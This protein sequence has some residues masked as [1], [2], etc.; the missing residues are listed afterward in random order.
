MSQATCIIYVRL[1]RDNESSTSV[2]SQTAACRALAESRGWDVLLVAEDVDVSGASKLESRPGMARVLDMMGSAD[3]VIAAKL[4]RFARSVLEFALLSE[5]ATNAGTILITTD[6]TL[7][8]ESSK[9]MTDILS[10]FAAHERRVIQERIA[11]SKAHLR[12]VGRWLGGAAPYGF[13]TVRRDGGTYLDVDP[14]SAA[15]VRSVA[16]R[17]LRKGE[18]LTGCMHWLN[19]NSVPSPAD[20]TRKRNGKEIKG[21]RWSTTTLRDVLINPALRGW[22]CYTPPSAPRYEIKYLVPVLNAAGEPHKVGPEIL[23]G[24][25][26]DALKDLLTARSVSPD[27]VGRSLLLHVAHCA[28][29]AG[30]LYHQRRV[31]RGQRYDSYLC[32]AAVGKHV[33]NTV[34]AAGLNAQVE[35]AFLAQFGFYGM[36]VKV[37]SRG[38]DVARELRETDEALDNLAALGARLTDGG[39]GMLAVVNQINALDAKRATLAAEAATPVREEWRDVGRTV[40]EEWA[41]RTPEGRNSLLREFGTH[42]AVTPLEK[43]AE[44]R[45]TTERT[46]VTFAG[47]EWV[48]DSNPYE[49]R[50]A[51]I[52]MEDQLSQ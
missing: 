30:P 40:A 41:S 45:F 13:R 6:G 46:A 5:F 43:T 23:A 22:L 10:A 32:T 17:I 39:R 35:A 52:E 16:E 28:V 25:T 37:T 24:E 12:R 27:R 4:D 34:N 1:S 3:Y 50:M 8:P 31:V 9:L 20:H 51:E 48:R 33:P 15:V 2:A 26:Y 7:G 21:T 38:R 18:S 36:Q 42:A 14:E 29:C 44:R 47:P 19:D 49:R 11:A